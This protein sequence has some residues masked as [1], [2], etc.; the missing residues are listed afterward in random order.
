MICSN[1]T[2]E[3]EL[4]DFNDEEEGVEPQKSH[5]AN[6]DIC[7]DGIDIG[8]AGYGTACVPESAVVY[9]K[10]CNGVPHI[11]IWADINQEDPTHTISLENAKES[12]RKK[13][14]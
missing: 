1:F 14:D 2:Q 3:F 12:M 9:I 5:K 11:L 8:F 4:K 10:M 7:D 13:K 6:I